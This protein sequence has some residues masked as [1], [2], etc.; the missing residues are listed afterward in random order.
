M[1]Y[2]Q[3]TPFQD[4]FSAAEA[5]GSNPAVYRY[6]FQESARL[7]ETEIEKFKRLN[8][9]FSGDLGETLSALA[10]RQMTVQSTSVE[11]VKASAIGAE[12]PDFSL[13][14]LLDIE[15]LGVKAL[16]GMNSTLL[17]AFLEALLGAKA[18]RTESP[19]RELTEV[20][21]SVLRDIDRVIVKELESS[22]Q[23]VAGLACTIQSQKSNLT[24]K[25]L[26][27]ARGTFILASTAFLLD[28]AVGRISIIYPAQIVQSLAGTSAGD[29]PPAPPSSG[30]QRA[31][32]EQLGTAKLLVEGC[33]QDSTVRLGDLLELQ[34]GDLLRLDLPLNL[35]L[36]IHLNGQ[37]RFQAEFFEG[38]LKKAM[39][40]QNLA[41]KKG[42]GN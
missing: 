20:E 15:P 24:P 23:A 40:I 16:L 26:S 14:F 21:Q 6:D 36:D 8:D 41:S 18:A 7:Q 34:P 42:P 17:F 35:P 33:L 2:S 28:D 5:P 4:S 27:S 38:D 25:S 1:D 9:R 3:T 30:L 10:R 39:R 12:S 11:Q 19:D 22:W 31:L 37:R 32:F 13:R 29:Q